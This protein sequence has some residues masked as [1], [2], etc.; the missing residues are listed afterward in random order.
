MFQTRTFDFRELKWYCI[1]F[2]EY[3]EIKISRKYVAFAETVNLLEILS[4]L[5]NKI[6]IIAYYQQLILLRWFLLGEVYFFNYFF[7]LFILGFLVA[8]QKMKILVLVVKSIDWKCFLFVVVWQCGWLFSFRRGYVLLLW[9]QIVKERI[10][11][12]FCSED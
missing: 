6:F 11:G 2:W 3:G 12:H 10:V 9:H 5:I 7:F 8:A 1:D 4:I